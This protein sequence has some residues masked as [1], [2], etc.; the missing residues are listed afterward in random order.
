M[1]IPDIL[2]SL[3]YDSV[4]GKKE[5]H[6]FQLVHGGPDWIYIFMYIIYWRQKTP[7]G[8]R[9]KNKYRT[10]WLLSTFYYFNWIQFHRCCCC[11]HLLLLCYYEVFNLLLFQIK[12]I[13]ITR[14]MA[15]F[16][17]NFF[18][19][20]NVAIPKCEYVIWYCL[21]SVCP[22]ITI[23]WICRFTLMVT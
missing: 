9:I 11:C 22:L 6:W 13:C 1:F 12:F 2:R 10:N 8:Y 15:L 4:G 19:N 14:R 23:M 7:H 16:C 18:S 20:S 5:R 3:N 17:I 21:S